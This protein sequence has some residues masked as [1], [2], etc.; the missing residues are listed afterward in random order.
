VAA[1]ADPVNRYAQDALWL[2]RLL[3]AGVSGPWHAKDPVWFVLIVT[4][5][6]DL[7]TPTLATIHTGQG[8]TVSVQA[9]AVP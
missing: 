4:R 5:H 9:S 6:L 8:P 3:G 1:E 7:A 2:F